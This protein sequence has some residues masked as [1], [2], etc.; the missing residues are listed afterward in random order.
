MW[1]TESLNCRVRLQHTLMALTLTTQVSGKVLVV[2]LFHPCVPEAGC[3]QSMIPY[4]C[5]WLLLLLQRC[6]FP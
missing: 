3:R 4:T 5:C 6:F 2:S 1:A